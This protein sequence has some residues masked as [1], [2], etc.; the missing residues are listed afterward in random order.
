M[1]YRTLLIT[2]FLIL[3]TGAVSGA[4]EEREGV[5]KEP[6][7]RIEVL[8][9]ARLIKIRLNEE[10]K[11]GVDWE[12]IVSNYQRLDLVKSQK[13]EEVQGRDTRLSLGTVTNEDYIVLLEALEVVGQI[14]DL[15][16]PKITV[17]I[18]REAKIVWDAHMPKSGFEIQLGISPSLEENGFLSINLDLKLRWLTDDQ[19]MAQERMEDTVYFSSSGIAVKV[20][21]DET[22]VIGGLMQ[23]TEIKRTSKLPLL[24][25]LPLVGFAFRRQNKL[26]ETT[27]YIIFLTPKIITE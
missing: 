6:E 3:S 22:I 11:Q 7:K 24:G 21:S 26:I 5:I 27:E 12:A 4:A 2:L 25:D 19:L 13:G 15:V 16:N 9:D 20:K 8:I 1:Q 14:R 23:E 18:N 10:H 17:A